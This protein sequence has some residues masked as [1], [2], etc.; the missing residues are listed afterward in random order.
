MMGIM[1]VIWVSSYYNFK[2]RDKQI[3][4]AFAQNNID[5]FNELYDKALIGANW[6]YNNK[7]ITKPDYIKIYCDNV[8]KKIKGYICD[9]TNAIVDA[10]FQNCQ[11]IDYPDFSALSV[12]G[13]MVDVSSAYTIDICS[14][15]DT[16]WVQ[17]NGSF[18]AKILLQFPFW[19]KLYAENAG[20]TKNTETDDQIVTG[21]SISAKKNWITVDF[22]LFTGN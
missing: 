12:E 13:R 2:D 19:V 14:Y 18:Y 6:F 7:G 8:Q 5:R 9:S 21:I 3:L 16:S 15:K 17:N 11:Q 20:N 22:P 4:E 1:A 10:T